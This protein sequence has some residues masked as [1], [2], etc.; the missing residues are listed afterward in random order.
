M[1]DVAEPW[2]RKEMTDVVFAS[3][4]EVIQTDYP[5]TLSQQPITKVRAYKAGSARH[6]YSHP[7]VSASLRTEEG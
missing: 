7:V 2:V 5:V 3:G 4:F 1:F 6:K